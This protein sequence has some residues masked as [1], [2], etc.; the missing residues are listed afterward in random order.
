MHYYTTGAGSIER[1][2]NVN[3]GKGAGD[4]L[5]NASTSTSTEAMA[6]RARNTALLHTARAVGGWYGICMVWH[7]YGV[8]QQGFDSGSLASC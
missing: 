2:D 5:N 4:D 7:K 3:N 6:K 1:N 8:P